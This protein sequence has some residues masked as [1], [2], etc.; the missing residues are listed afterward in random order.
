MPIS[1]IKTKKDGDFVHEVE[2]LC[3]GKWELPAL[4]YV[5]TNWLRENKDQLNDGPYLAS[6]SFHPRPWDSGTAAIIN[7]ETMQ[8]MASIQNDVIAA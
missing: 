4:V 8:T 3:T 6:I 5:F 7:P 1:V 2:D